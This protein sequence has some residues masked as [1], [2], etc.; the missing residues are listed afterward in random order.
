MKYIISSLKINLKFVINLKFANKYI[1][2]ER[3]ADLS[4]WHMTHVSICLTIY[5]LLILCCLFLNLDLL[6]IVK[7]F[8]LLLLN[9]DF[10]STLPFWQ[11][12]LR[13]SASL[14]KGY[15]FSIHSVWWDQFYFFSFFLWLLIILLPLNITNVK[16]ISICSFK[17]YCYSSISQHKSHN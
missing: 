1:F 13:F 2:L 12:Q 6:L 10:D 17:R 7:S 11:H 15:I 5:L 14:F 8:L 16:D 3:K 9:L 4:L